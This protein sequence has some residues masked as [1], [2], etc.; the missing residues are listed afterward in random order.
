MRFDV[1]ARPFEEFGVVGTEIKH[2]AGTGTFGPQIEGR[3]L[4]NPVFVVAF[5]RPR[6]EEKQEKLVEHD[7]RRQGFE[8]FFGVG[9]EK[10]DIAQAGEIAFAQGA[11]D[12]LGNQVDT[13]AIFLRESGTVRGEKVPVTAADFESQAVERKSADE[14]FRQRSRNAFAQGVDALGA[15]RHGFF[16]IRHLKPVPC[17]V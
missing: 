11:F 15:I 12:A 13:D 8:E 3:V 16:V 10:I 7:L 5:F 1:F 9:F 17:A 14:F 4:N 6:I 2:G